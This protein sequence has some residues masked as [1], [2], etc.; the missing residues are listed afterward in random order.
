MNAL[1]PG[2]LEVLGAYLA[3]F[4]PADTY[5]D[6]TDRLLS[7]EIIIGDLEDAA[8]LSM[9]DVADYMVARGYHYHCLHDDGIAGW[10]LRPKR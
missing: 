10:I 4:I 7:T 3:P 8:T 9:N 1:T 6:D 2:M 5:N